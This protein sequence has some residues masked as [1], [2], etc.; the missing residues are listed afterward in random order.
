VGGTGAGDVSA[1]YYGAFAERTARL[2]A[3][4]RLD[5]PLVVIM[6]NGTSGNINNVN[7]GSPI[8][9]KRNPGEQIQIVA[10]S[11]ADAAMGAYETLKWNAQPKLASEE[12]D[13]MLG[14]RKATPDELAKAKEVLA[15]VPKD[16]DGQWADRKAIYAREAVK[17]ADYPDTVPVK[18]QVHRIGDLT[19]AAIPCEVFVEIGLDLKKN[20]P[21][22]RH[23]TISL[24]NGYNGYLPT[25]E[26]HALGG[27]ETWRARSSYLE[28][29]A[30]TK[31]VEH[32]NALLAKLK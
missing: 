13:I 29:N 10:R 28:V 8:R 3:G 26:H 7:F 2:L 9:Y 5:P 25:P 16:K 32:L 21:L 20:A 30:S 24:A 15:T 22:T 23:F 27:Y 18:L 1:D 31:I 19:I 11:V 12:E 4:D 17:L 6:S 14:V